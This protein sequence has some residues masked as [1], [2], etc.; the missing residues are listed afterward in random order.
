M[1]ANDGSVQWSPSVT[2][3][4]KGVRDQHGIFAGSPLI[5]GKSIILN[6]GAEG[7]SLVCLNP[8]N[9]K[10]I[11]KTGT[12][13][14]VYAS[15]NK[16]NNVEEFFLFHADGLSVHR[17]NDGC[18]K[19]F[20]QHKTRYGINASQPVEIGDKV[21]L[22]SAYGKGTALVDFSSSKPK[23][24]WKTGKNIFPDVYTN[25]IWGIS[26]WNLWTSWC[27]IKVFHLILL[28]CKEWKGNLGKKGFGLEP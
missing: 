26:I 20:Y 1:D 2:R 28:R 7:S 4:L 27:T 16:R 21:L 8:A 9:G 11:W 14:A 25:S 17:M 23:A 5:Y 12:Y 13:D 18:E 24:L 6:I 19:L 15:I 3:D 22:S 10:V